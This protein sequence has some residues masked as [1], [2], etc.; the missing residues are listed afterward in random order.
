MESLIEDLLPTKNSKDNPK[1]VLFA[2]GSTQFQ[3]IQNSGG[4]VIV[5]GLDAKEGFTF[6][7]CVLGVYRRRSVS[8]Q[9]LPAWCQW[10]VASSLVNL[11]AMRTSSMP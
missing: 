6:L 2:R 1:C 11:L 9:T 8:A 4:K 5:R 10:G 7:F 3:T